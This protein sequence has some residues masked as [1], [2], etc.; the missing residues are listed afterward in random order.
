MRVDSMVAYVAAFLFI[1]LER[2]LMVQ[3]LPLYN[4]ARRELYT[5]V[6]DD[7]FERFQQY[8][9]RP[10]SKGYVIRSFTVEG[11]EIVVSLHREILKPPAGLVV[12]HVNRDKLDN[13]RINLRV[14]TVAEN[15]MNRGLFKNNTTQAKG[16]AVLH[17]QFH[18][19]IEKDGRDLHL[20]DFDDLRTAAL[21]YDCAAMILYGSAIPWRNLPDEQIS[22]V[23]QQQVLQR[24]STLLTAVRH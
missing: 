24:L 21:T 9:W 18:A 17:G 13:R 5:L 6:D 23:I 1:A 19:R 22:D 20:G 12:D 14:L 3:K 8:R 10:N 11:K 4:R 7:D 2:H 16:V 15:A